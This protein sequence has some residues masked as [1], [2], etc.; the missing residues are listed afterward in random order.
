MQR[1][2]TDIMQHVFMMFPKER[3]DFIWFHEEPFSDQ[4]IQEPFF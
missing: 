4:F 3:S 1:L 2:G